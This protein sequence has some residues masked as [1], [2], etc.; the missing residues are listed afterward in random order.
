MQLQRIDNRAA[1][2]RPAGG[3]TLAELMIAMGILAFG[4]TLAAAMFPAAARLNNQSIREVLGNIICENAI[5]VTRARLEHDRSNPSS[6]TSTGQLENVTDKFGNELNYPSGDDSTRRG[7]LVLARR[8]SNEG[9]HTENDYQFVVVA[10]QKS[11]PGT[12]IELKK[13]SATLKDVELESDEKV[14]KL[15][16]SGG[17]SLQANSVVVRADTGAISYIDGVGD[18]GNFA[19]L[20]TRLPEGSTS[21]WVVRETGSSAGFNVPV[22]AAYTVEMSL[23]EKE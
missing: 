3:F 12:G 10:Y 8:L 19:I 9:I 17:G 16:V 15:T 4:L 2:R 23:R 21:V 11:T 18:G 7:A 20:K 14:T 1:P 5:A 13:L 6:I 22:L